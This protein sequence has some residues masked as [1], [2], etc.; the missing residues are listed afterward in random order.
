MKA[1][2]FNKR[3]L[4]LIT[5]VLGIFAVFLY[6]QYINPELVINEPKPNIILI[7]IDGASWQII[8]K[9]I[10]EGKMVNLSKLIIEGTRGD[11]RSLP[12]RPFNKSSSP[13]IW[14]SIATGKSSDK[15]GILGFTYRSNKSKRPRLYTSDLRETKAF[16]NILS[17]KGLKVGVVGWWNTWP[18]EEVNGVMVTDHFWPAKHSKVGF[19]IGS[20]GEGKNLSRRTY[21][22][23]LA[24]ELSDKI[25]TE[26]DIPVEAYSMILEE[27][28]SKYIDILGNLHWPYARDTTYF[29]VSKQL[30]GQDKYDL[31]AVYFES[32]DIVS[33]RNWRFLKGENFFIP[34]VEQGI[35][36]REFLEQKLGAKIPAYYEY[37]DKLI[38]ELLKFRNEETIVIIVSDHGFETYADLR[39]LEW[40]NKKI[41]SGDKVPFGHSEKGILVIQ[42]KNIKRGYKISGATIYDITP[43]ILYL[44]H[45]K[46]GQDMDGKVLKDAIKLDYLKKN[47]I[48][49]CSSYDDHNWKNKKQEMK[50][51]PFDEELQERLKSLGYTGF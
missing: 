29:N 2:I 38:G 31:F 50:P 42:G 15:H 17:E 39:E 36:T 5:G 43:T 11:L 19:I 14:A 9:M 24:Q 47:P 33:H 27:R 3:L 49:Y 35:L 48:K 4:L 8:D 26:D 28:D 22:E 18:A 21:P 44:L 16:W 51:G 30:L 23:F 37:I 12:V 41:F 1:Q 45:L 34:K 40:K 13:V 32:L 10:L 46:V 25:I 20:S 7:G 6:I